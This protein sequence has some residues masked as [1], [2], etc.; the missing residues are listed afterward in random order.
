M[1][2]RPVPTDSQSQ[3]A[4]S[5]QQANPADVPSPSN[6][7]VLGSLSDIAG[8][9][10]MSFKGTGILKG[11]G[12]ALEPSSSH[13][14]RPDVT[15]NLKEL[16]HKTRVPPK[17]QHTTTTQQVPEEIDL[18]K[19]PRVP[20]D[21]LDQK[22]VATTSEHTESQSAK[23]QRTDE[24]D[25]SA[26]NLSQGHLW[27]TAIDPGVS[28]SLVPNANHELIAYI[29]PILL[30]GGVTNPGELLGLPFY[31]PFIC[32][33]RKR[34][35]EWNPA[36]SCGRWT[37]RTKIDV[38]AL[39]VQLTGDYSPKCCNRCDPEIGL[40]KGCIITH[41]KTLARTY[42][43][44]TNCLYHGR[45]T[46]C[47]LKS[48]NRQ[49]GA[50]DPGPKKSISNDIAT[51]VHER[52]ELSKSTMITRPKH[53]S[54]TPDAPRETSLIAA[55]GSNETSHEPGQILSME[56]WERAPGRIRSQVSAAP[57]SKR[58]YAPVRDFNQAD[59]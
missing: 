18:T 46:F 38:V 55:G 45:Q 58:A 57:E 23:R 10:S 7:H 51:T 48:W 37:F 6:G 25:N 35:M 39:L 5:A 1:S 53:G 9:S 40:F 41:S 27:N 21:S 52:G 34:D 11:T 54:S 42:Y 26:R 32:N 16:I 3:R 50:T 56:P 2:E 24:G 8:P 31:Q 28:A 44:C 22:L 13:R 49:N 30:D 43:G 59:H 17:N 20:N 15:Y 33:P 12:P 29:W 36:T 47:N 19:S 14:Q 4:A